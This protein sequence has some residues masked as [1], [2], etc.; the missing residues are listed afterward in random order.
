VYAQG[1]YD[2]SHGCVNVAPKNAAWIYQNSHVGDPVSI[3][4]TG[5]QVA[6]GNGWTA[7]NSSWSDFAKGSALGYAPSPTTTGVTP[8]V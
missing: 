6:N 4:G 5:R 8:T 2:V 7:W 1:H 3:V